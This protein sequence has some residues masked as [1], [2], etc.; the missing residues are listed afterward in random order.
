MTIDPSNT[1]QTAFLSLFSEAQ[2]KQL[3]ANGKATLRHSWFGLPDVDRMPVALLRC[4]CG[5]YYLLSEIDP[6]DPTV[7]YCVYED[8]EGVPTLDTVDFD[9]MYESSEGTDH[10]FECVA[11]FVPSGTLRTYYRKARQFRSLSRVFKKPG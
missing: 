11:G 1:A 2:K 7:A 6:T 4:T 5:D 10:G 8:S 9:A 3:F